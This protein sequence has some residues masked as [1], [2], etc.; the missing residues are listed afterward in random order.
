MSEAR[1]PEEMPTDWQVKSFAHEQG[2]GTLSHALGEEAVFNI[3]A[4]NLGSWKPS[5]REALSQRQAALLPRVGEPVRVTWKRSLS[6]KTVP[7]QVQPT[8]RVS[9]GKEYKLSA[10]LKAVQRHTGHFAAIKPASL[11]EALAELDPDLADEWRDSEPRSAIDFAMLLMSIGQLREVAPDWFAEHAA[12]VYTDDWR[13]DRERG[14]ATLPQ[15][16]GISATP[17]LA[18]ESEALEEY[19]QRCNAQA[20]TEGRELRLY[21]VDTDSDQYVVLALQ[22]EA[23]A[24]LVKDEYLA[25]SE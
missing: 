9:I 18:S 8:G 3:D 21:S 23:F 6:G 4:W 22:P 13:W 16:L 11:L 10:W 1:A 14:M 19:A 15:M 20:A 24:A 7:A 25:A 2:F 17:A 5:R 12:W